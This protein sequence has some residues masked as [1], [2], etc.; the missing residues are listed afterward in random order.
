M[1][2]GFFE[3]IPEIQQP[4]F[5]HPRRAPAHQIGEIHI[6]GQVL[7]AGVLIDRGAF[8]PLLE[9]ITAEGAVR[10]AVIEI[11]RGGTVVDGE[12]APGFPRGQPFRQI[13]LI[14][15]VDFDELARWVAV[16]KTG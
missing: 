4:L 9:K 15:L 3:E 7:A 5:R 2:G 11:V 12:H 13:F 8:Q 16:E 10:A 6:G 1:G 14:G